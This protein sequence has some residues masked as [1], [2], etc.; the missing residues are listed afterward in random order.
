MG[1]RVVC[2]HLVPEDVMTMLVSVGQ[3]YICQYAACRCEIEIKVIPPSEG[4]TNPRCVCGSEM[5]KVYSKPEIRRLTK[6]KAMRRFGHAAFVPTGFG[7]IAGS[8]HVQ[9]R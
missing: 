7:S 4:K 1:S 9:T 5:K 2:T 3:R 8:E 6:S